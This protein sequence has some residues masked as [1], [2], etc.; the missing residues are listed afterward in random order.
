MD[1]AQDGA[2]GQG[3]TNAGGDTATSK[4]TM[5]VMVAIVRAVRD[6]NP[7]RGVKKLVALTKVAHPELEFGAREVRA[8][9]EVIK[10]SEVQAPEKE[11]AE[12]SVGTAQIAV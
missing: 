5:D 9:L 4:P 8:A 12:V 1:K 3:S 2:K 7:E 6:A 11:Q 10:R